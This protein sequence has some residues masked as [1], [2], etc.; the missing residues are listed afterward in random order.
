MNPLFAVRDALKEQEI[1][2]AGQLATLLQFPQTRVEEILQH[3]QR[4]GLV[5][6][7]LAAT[8]N[9]CNSGGCSS[10]SGCGPSPTRYHWRNG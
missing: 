7:V 8:S 5:E 2:T 9:G 4:R 6:Q 3:W 10:C 1:A